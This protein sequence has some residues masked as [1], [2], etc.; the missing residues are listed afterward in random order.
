MTAKKILQ[1]ISP[2]VFVKLSRE[3]VCSCYLTSHWQVTCCPGSESSI[4]FLP[5]LLT[6]AEAHQR[7]FIFTSA[8][9]AKNKNFSYLIFQ[10]N[11][12]GVS[13]CI[14]SSL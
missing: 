1:K 12:S 4:E 2:E 7:Q 14:D 3:A 9:S 5:T 11:H 13:G 8:F 6:F 10:F